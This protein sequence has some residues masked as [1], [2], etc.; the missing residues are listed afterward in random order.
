MT[1]FEKLQKEK[2]IVP[3][4]TAKIIRRIHVSKGRK[5]SKAKSETVTNP[6]GSVVPKKKIRHEN[7]SKSSSEQGQEIKFFRPVDVGSQDCL[8]E[9]EEDDDNKIH[10]VR[11]TNDAVH[12]IKITEEF[13]VKA[14]IDTGCSKL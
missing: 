1:S 9:A 13:Y 8:F 6:D 2:D 3:G 10:E 11:F 5:I 4:A 7:S 14:I 12:S